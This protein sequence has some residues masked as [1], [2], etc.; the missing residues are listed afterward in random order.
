MFFLL[1]HF[2][3]VLVVRI[4]VYQTDRII[5]PLLRK[6]CGY[7]E[8]YRGLVLKVEKVTSHRGLVLKVEMVTVCDNC[9]NRVRVITKQE[10]WWNFSCFG[11]QL[12]YAD[13]NVG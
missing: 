5:V 10:P 11:L 3:E 7:C 6:P 8:L 4:W 1:S 12:V 2:C 9:Y 13:A